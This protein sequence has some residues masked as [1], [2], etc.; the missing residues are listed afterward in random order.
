MLLVAFRWSNAILAGLCVTI[1][2]PHSAWAQ[3]WGARFPPHPNCRLTIRSAAHVDSSV[4]GAS[5]VVVVRPVGFT[6]RERI[7]NALAGLAP[8]GQD[9]PAAKGAAWTSD[10]ASERTFRGLPVGR[11]SLVVRSIGYLSRTDTIEVRPL[12]IDTV[13]VPLEEFNEGYRNIHNCRARGFRRNGEPACITEG[14]WAEHELDY[15]RDLARAAHAT[16]LKLPPL[17]T[18]RIS[19]VRDEGTC[20]QAGRAYGRPDD[21]PRRVVVVQMDSLYLVYDPFEPIPMGEWDL[22][23]IFG[24][25]WRPLVSL[26][27]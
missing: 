16:L 17:D 27:S 14:F 26:A 7:R 20:R 21:P 13:V 18:T 4:V 24:G 9:N 23:R 5:S 22:H 11:Y 19:L 2:L 10:T 1:V 3:D 15:G 8:L 25:S 12:G 6:S